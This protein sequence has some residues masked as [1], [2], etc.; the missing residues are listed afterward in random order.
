M[1]NL[2]PLI[3]GGTDT[4]EKYDT[5]KPIIDCRNY[6]S[7]Q[8]AINNAKSGDTVYIPG[9]NYSENLILNKTIVL[10]GDDKGSTTVGNRVFGTSVIVNAEDCRINN[11][12]FFT[13]K[14]TNCYE[15]AGI[16][17][18]SNNCT[19]QN[20]TFRYCEMGIHIINSLNILIRNNVFKL[21]EY[22]IYL[23]N[24]NNNLIETNRIYER[25]GVCGILLRD[26]HYNRIINNTV[27]ETRIHS[28]FLIGSEYNDIEN[29]LFQCSENGVS[30]GN[31]RWNNIRHNRIIGSYCRDELSEYVI[32]GHMH[33]T[34]TI[35][36]M[37]G[38][39]Y[40]SS[41]DFGYG[42]NLY[43]SNQNS[44][45]GNTVLNWERGAIYIWYSDKNIIIENVL[46]NSSD[47]MSFIGSNNNTVMK[48]YCSNN[49]SN[50]DRRYSL[51]QSG[52]SFLYS[53]STEIISNCLENCRI[54][55]RL[56]NSVNNVINNNIFNNC[57]K[58]D[59]YL[60]S[61]N[62][63]SFNNNNGT[64]YNSENQ[65][66]SDL[67]PAF[68]FFIILFSIILLLISI[69]LFILRKRKSERKTS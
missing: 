32:S 33:S 46:L 30:L 39:D 45:I 23:N 19:I 47:G 67:F 62:N 16:E 56:D 65:T 35:F 2:L 53:N 42:M 40:V 49:N 44:I 43:S 29:N 18:R 58:H 14:R 25:N 66:E 10:K 13:T 57:R 55:I 24:S 3:S 26:S 20:C 21:C 68:I 41:H 61:S 5:A 48:N 69:A 8:E 38:Y 17:I 15:Y 7:I 27:E 60:T 63:N 51:T 52:L 28:I 59:I 64:I 12:S 11:I 54:G 4:Y 1:V 9:G 22:A 6:K 50:I 37:K 31:S 34:S 36:S